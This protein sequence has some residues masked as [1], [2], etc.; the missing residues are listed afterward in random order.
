MENTFYSTMEAVLKLAMLIVIQ[1][2][3]KQGDH[4]NM[5]G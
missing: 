5:G 1:F 2:S 4:V 3:V